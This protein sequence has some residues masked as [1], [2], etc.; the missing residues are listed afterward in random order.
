M[1]RLP[2]ASCQLGGVSGATPNPRFRPGRAFVEKL[3][4]LDLVIE[5]LH[6]GGSVRQT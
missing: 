3:E 6:A 4:G 5:A 2:D 1:G